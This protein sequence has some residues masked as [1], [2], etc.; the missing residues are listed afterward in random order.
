MKAMGSVA[1]AA[2]L[3]ASGC[4]VDPLDSIQADLDAKPVST[5]RAAVDEL[6]QM[7]NRASLDTLVDAFTHD[8]TIREAGAKALVIRGREW[9]RTHPKDISGVLTRLGDIAASQH[10]DASLRATA[11][12]AM[13]EIGDR[14]AKT[15][16]VAANG[17]DSMAVQNEV[18]ISLTKLGFS[19]GENGNGFGM[20]L[21][22][23]GQT[24]VAT[25]DPQERGHT[26]EVGE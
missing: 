14:H 5:R 23:D 17:A 12:W 11:V 18:A 15:F 20:E 19:D 7:S 22:A 9:K 21:L 4:G 26:E 8:P 1:C 24:T 3:I 13:G 25:Y 2:L 6:A 16:I 10:T